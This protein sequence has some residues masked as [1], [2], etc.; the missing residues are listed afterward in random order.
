MGIVELTCPLDSRQHLESSHCQKQQ[1]SEYLQLLAELDRLNI[2]NYYST[3]EVST[4]AKSMCRNYESLK[5]QALRSPNTV[6]P[7]F[8]T[9]CRE[10]CTHMLHYPKISKNLPTIY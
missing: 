4:L 8:H 7:I 9:T 1:K 5:F 6:T 10:R 3:V 2:A